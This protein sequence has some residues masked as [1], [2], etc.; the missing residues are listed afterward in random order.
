MQ[1]N[2]RHTDKKHKHTLELCGE[3]IN[4]L[5]LR[6]RYRRASDPVGGLAG[7]GKETP[8]SDRKTHTW[9]SPYRCGSGLLM[10]KKNP[11]PDPNLHSTS[12][13]RFRPS[14]WKNRTRIGL[15]QSDSIGNGFYQNVRIRI[16]PRYPESGSGSTSLVKGRETF[17]S[18]SFTA[19]WNGLQAWSFH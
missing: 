18:V 5:A 17:C 8:V 15:K 13:N 16:W 19:Q 11:K 4:C 1:V 2:W 9:T 12:F 6:I 3:K 14:V 7:S 10:K